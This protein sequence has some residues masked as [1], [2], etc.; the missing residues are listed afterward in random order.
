MRIDQTR[1]VGSRLR[2]L[3]P[4]GPLGQNRDFVA[5]WSAATVSQLG[6]QVSLLALPFVAITTLEASTLEVA[7]LGIAELVPLLLF[8]LPAGAWIDRVRR[9]PVMI[10]AD[11][12]CACAFV[13]IPSA[14]AAGVL[15]IWQLYVVGFATGTFAMFFDVASQ[16][17]LPAIVPREELPGANAALQV[18]AQTAQVGGPGLAGLLV[19]VLG[20]PYAIAADAASYL[21]SAALLL[22]V[23]QHET[24]VPKEHRRAMRSEIREGL[25]YVLRHPILR[26][27]LM[28]TSTANIFNTILFAVLLLFSVRHLHLSAR[29]I[30]LILMLANVG[31][32]AGALATTRLQRRFGLG[33]VMLATAFGGWALLLIPFASGAGRIPM[34]AAGL[35]LWGTAVVVFNATSATLVQATAPA[36]LLS[37]VFAS[38]RLVSWGVMPVGTLLG[39]L[40]GTYFGLRTAVFVGAGGRALA[41]LI[42]LFSPVRSIRTLDDAQ[43]LVAAYNATAMVPAA[44]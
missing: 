24:A 44:E 33:R 40:L 2:A 23:K 43:A 3:R 31:S 39:G 30:G 37:R 34:I 28:F 14:Y 17:F 29:Q 10:A 11:L 13:S 18:S 8:G 22:R 41:G 42:I 7:M 1:T 35:L 36:R 20:A 12:T 26:P 5:I 38:R 15:T 6:T 25:A 9:R 19:S 16:S 27:N 32:L 21:G 4:R